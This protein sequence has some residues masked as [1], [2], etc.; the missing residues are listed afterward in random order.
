MTTPW[1]VIL[2]Q[3][4]RPSGPLGML[5]GF[6][7]ANRASNRRRN[8][9]TVEML[10]PGA[11][12]RM[13]ELGCGPGLA[14]RAALDRGARFVLAFDH[15]P[16]MIR[17][18]GLRCRD[19][20]AAGRAAFRLG[21]L[22]RLRPEDGPFDAALMVNVAQFLPNR[23]EA[24]ARIARALR[25][26]GRL[27]VT[28]QPRQPGATAAD[29]GAFAAKIRQDLSDAGFGDIAEHTL[30]LKPVPAVCVVGVVPKEGVRGA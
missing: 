21:S 22:D 8:A 16:E 13:L 14:V 26:G 29:A 12:E 10:A 1:G 17:Q 3:F 19:D 7:M 25:P 27:A 9:W 5:A 18:A 20:V 24:F 6:I 30:P 2:A 11:G 23:A 28:H 15:S 4:R